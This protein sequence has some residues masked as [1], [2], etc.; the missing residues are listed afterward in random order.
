MISVAVSLSPSLTIHM[1]KTQS[2]VLNSFR[3]FTNLSNLFCNIR[4]NELSSYRKWYM[5]C[6]WYGLCVLLLCGARFAQSI[7]HLHACKC[8]KWKIFHKKLISWSLNFLLSANVY[9]YPFDIRAWLFHWNGIYTIFINTH[10]QIDTRL[11]GIFSAMVSFIS[12]RLFWK[13]YFILFFFEISTDVAFSSSSFFCFL[14]FLNWPTKLNLNIL[15]V[16]MMAFNR[17]K[18]AMFIHF[19]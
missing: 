18:W 2:F 3:Q 19:V 1:W 12:S 5:Q 9:C 14:H 6:L 10:T 4:F 13:S 15:N 16:K 11:N 17:V 8:V 7:E